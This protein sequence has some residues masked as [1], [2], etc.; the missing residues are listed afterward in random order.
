MAAKLRRYKENARNGLSPEGRQSGALKEGQAI[1]SRTS[2]GTVGSL[3]R[4][5]PARE[6]CPD[7]HQRRKTGVRLEERKTHRNS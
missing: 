3:E 6:D 1:S 5:S 7:V 4:P 2:R